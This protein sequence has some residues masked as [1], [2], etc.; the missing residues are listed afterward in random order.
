MGWEIQ[1]VHCLYSVQDG[2]HAD[3]ELVIHYQ[4]L[5]V[6]HAKHKAEPAKTAKLPT[7]NHLPTAS[8][9]TVLTML[10]T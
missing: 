7:V 5:S 3:I 4:M 8:L 10:A 6:P 1:L 9:L 2:E